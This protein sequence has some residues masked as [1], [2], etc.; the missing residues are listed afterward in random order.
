MKRI[1]GSVARGERQEKTM[2]FYGDHIIVFTSSN[3]PEDI[4]RAFELGAN[5]YVVKPPELEELEKMV[6]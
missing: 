1:D 2:P 4:K 3:L 5:S 6:R